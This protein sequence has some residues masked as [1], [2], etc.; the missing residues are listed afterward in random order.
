MCGDG[1]QDAEED[2]DDGNTLTEECAYGEAACTVCAADC[3][4]QAGAVRVCGDGIQDAEEGCDDGNTLTE[5]C[6]YGEAACTVCA[7][8]CTEQ[9]GVVRICGDGIQDAEEGCDDGNTLTEECAYGEAACTVCAADCTEQAGAVLPCRERDPACVPALFADAPTVDAIDYSYW[10][11]PVNHRPI[12]R[13]GDYM[14]DMHILTGHY[15]FEFNEANGALSR[16]GI[17]ADRQPVAAARHRSNEDILALPQGQ[18][19]FEAGPIAEDVHIDSFL[20]P[21]GGHDDRAQLRDSG[22][23]MNF[24]EFPHV[25]YAN[26]PEGIE[27]RVDIASM[28]RHIVFSHTANQR[29]VRV[30]LS[31]ALLNGLQGQWLVE[32]RALRM[33][34]EQGRG[35][36]FVVYGTS[37]IALQDGA[38]VAEHVGA[39]DET[40]TVSLLAA[41]LSA[42]S[43]AEV[44]MY[45]TPDEAAV[46][47]YQLLDHLGEPAGPELPF[48][49]SAKMGA[50]RVQLG[51]LSAAG[52]VGPVDYDARPELHNWYGR[53]RIS[54]D[55]RGQR[56][57]IPMAYFGNG[58]ASLYITGGVGS[59]R[60]AA[61][62]PIGV[63]VQISKNW[64]DPSTGAW[65]HFYTQPVF[66]GAGPVDL[67]FTIASSRWGAHAYASSHAQ[68]SLIG[69]NSAGGHWDE[70]A[71][72][73]FGESITYDPDVTLGRAMVD[74]VRPFLVQA[75][76]KW[77]W[78]G[79]VGGADFLRYRSAE[80]PNTLRRLGRL[81][82]TYHDYGP[83][84]TDV[85]YSGITSDGR[86]SANIGVQMGRTDDLVRT[87]YH[88]EYT[89]NEDVRYDRLAFFQMA[90]DN[91]GD[92]GFA[93]VAWGN[94]SEVVERRDIPDHR[95]TGYAGADDRGIPLV[96]DS[97]W[98]MLYDNR[99]IDERLPEHFADLVFV[100]RDFEARI[101]DELI[102]TP[103]LSYTERLTG[104]PNTA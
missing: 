92:N 70:S 10:Y 88:L 79:N 65:Y 87:Y 8:D 54:V 95:T 48:E 29:Q 59:L 15:G 99:L 11:W 94:G 45:I 83:N 7:A 103:H 77:S 71:L 91:Y 26:A 78:T 37:T 85:E 49:W 35:W 22:R 25:T 80:E 27:G 90:A 30:R 40:N 41:P 17:F 2:C 53:H 38:V 100:V 4:E 19:K 97:P 3:T 75:Q 63:P 5:E 1:I 82:S 36:L 62:E 69:Y 24:V 28:P 61:G 93:S 9:A 60:D 67:E 104:G 51:T 68:L 12:L 18:I 52:L 23:F 81:R 47:R 98:V 32:N 50:Y 58:N 21:E 13:R 14:R 57:A 31:N 33:A 66:S 89:F 34:D 56:L 46:I 20:S 39:V 86:I 64:H 96:G 72:G 73:A 55:T 84:L 42:L 102:A 43:E 101:G 74:D 16:L 44:A 6:A 76:N